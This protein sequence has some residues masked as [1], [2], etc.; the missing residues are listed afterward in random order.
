MRNLWARFNHFIFVKRKLENRFQ[1][2]YILLTT[3]LIF[4]I[5]SNLFLKLAENSAYVNGLLVDYL[6]PKIYAS[7]VVIFILLGLWIADYC[8]TNLKHMSRWL[9]MLRIGLA[10]DQVSNLLVITLVISIILL[11]ARQFFAEK[12]LAALWF[13][14]KI[15]EMILL[16]IFLWKHRDIFKSKIIGWTLLGTFFF[17]ACLGIYQFQTQKS[18]FPSYYFLGEINYSHPILL[19][20]GSFNGAEKILPYGTTAHPNIW[21]SCLVLM[22]GIL[23]LNSNSKQKFRWLS[24]LRVGLGR[25]QIL[26]LV[27]GII[28]SFSTT[29][30]LLYCLYIAQSI[31]AW[32]CFGLACSVLLI[33]QIK[34]PRRVAV[35][36]T[37]VV[38]VLVLVTVVI[39]PLVI[40]QLA[41]NDPGNSSY[42]RRDELNQAAANMIS[43]NYLTGVGLNNFT[44]QVEKYAHSSEVVRFVQPVHNIF[45]LWLA[46]S[47]GLG[48]A[49]IITALIYLLRQEKIWRNF[50]V[51]LLSCMPLLPLSIFDHFLLTQQ[52]GLLL[53][54]MLLLINTRRSL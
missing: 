2:A 36:D 21:I 44:A 52:T 37:I 5:P 1:R 10:R 35:L 8:I 46:E 20:T 15:I 27:R 13:L 19:D 18:F 45:L 11:F 25:D 50:R 4:L 24:I 34:L 53:G 38:A 42:V 14:S 16:V 41:V 9:T 12:P 32:L 30:L 51:I 40:Q 49:I 43:A 17:Q 39:S 7:D 33:N 31:E 48:I 22:W 47:G 29:A 3:V 6:L 54:I 28:L 26:N 23:S